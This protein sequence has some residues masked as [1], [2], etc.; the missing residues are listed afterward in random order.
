M[1][2]RIS[3][4]VLDKTTAQITGNNT[5]VI[6][7]AYRASDDIVAV[8]TQTLDDSITKGTIEIRVYN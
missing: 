1:Y 4:V 6:L 7:A 2:T 5:S 8:N 3:I